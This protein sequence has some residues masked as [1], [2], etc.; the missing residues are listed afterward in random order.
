[1]ILIDFSQVS[2]GNL[3]QQL[4]QNTTTFPSEQPNPVQPMLLR[5][6]ILNSIR[7]INKDFGREYGKVVV[8]TDNHNYWRK[9]YFKPYKAN[10]KKDRDESGIDW[11]LVFHTLNELRSEL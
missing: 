5:H 1:M 2:I 4:K 10:R 9:L 6:M 3:H 8:C 11:P 7:K